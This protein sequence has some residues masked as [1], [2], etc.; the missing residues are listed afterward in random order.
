MCHLQRGVGLFSH[1]SC[2]LTS[3]KNPR[4]EIDN[5]KFNIDTM[6]SPLF[7]QREKVLWN[8]RDFGK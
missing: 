8:C 4:R 1:S 2:Y 5:E 6:Q 3:F 7:G